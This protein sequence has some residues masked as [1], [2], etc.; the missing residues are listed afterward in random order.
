MSVN[1]KELGSSYLPMTGNSTVD[2]AIQ[3]MR[4]Q[5]D[6]L[7]LSMSDWRHGKAELVLKDKDKNLLQWLVGMF[8]QF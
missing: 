4:N 5:C 3:L 1:L 7:N 6:Y 2:G 8:N